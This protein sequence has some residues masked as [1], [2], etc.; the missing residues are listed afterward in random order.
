MHNTALNYY[1]HA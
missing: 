1:D